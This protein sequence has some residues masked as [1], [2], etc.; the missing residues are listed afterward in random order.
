MVQDPPGIQTRAEGDGGIQ[1]QTLSVL[2]PIANDNGRQHAA[3]GPCE[4]QL[5]NE[6]DPPKFEIQLYS[7]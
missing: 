2:N 3:Q 7:K 4:G 1:S 5:K 6:S